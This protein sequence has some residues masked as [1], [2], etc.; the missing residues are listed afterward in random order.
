MAHFDVALADVPTDHAPHTVHHLERCPAQRLVEQ[1][2][3]AL[4]KVEGRRG[5]GH[6]RREF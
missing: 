6:V 2:G 1:Q 3:L 4:F 5:E